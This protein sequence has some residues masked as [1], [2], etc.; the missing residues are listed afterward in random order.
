MKK[1]LILTIALLVVGVFSF[2]VN[3]TSNMGASTWKTGSNSIDSVNVV[4][5][6]IEAAGS[7]SQSGSSTYVISKDFLVTVQVQNTINSPVLINSLQFRL[8][9]PSGSQIQLVSFDNYS[10]DLYISND[11]NQFFSLVPSNSFSYGSGIVVPPN[12]SIWAVGTISAQMISSTAASNFGLTSVSV[13]T[14]TTARG[15]VYTYG[16][17]VDWSPLVTSLDTYFSQEHLDNNN[18]LTLLG[19]IK[20]DSAST[21]SLLSDLI[22]SVSYTGTSYSYTGTVPSGKTF[23]FTPFTGVTLTV[24]RIVGA[25]YLIN[26][27]VYYNSSSDSFSIDQTVRYPFLY[28]ITIA[29]GTGKVFRSTVYNVFN[30]FYPSNYT[31]RGNIVVPSFISDTY[32][33]HNYHFNSEFYLKH[34]NG[35]YGYISSDRY[36]FTYLYGY[37]E[38]PKNAPVPVWND[39]TSSVTFTPVDDYYP[40]T[41]YDILRDLYNGFANSGRSDQDQLSSDITSTSNSI[42]AQEEQYFASNAQAIQA[43]GLSNYRFDQNQS[44]GISAVSNDFTAV[45]NALGGF[46]SVFIFSLTLS[47]ALQIFRHHPIVFRAKQV[48][49]TPKV[50][51]GDP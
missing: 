47:L 51:K 50:G 40:L 28:L 29:N 14:F 39:V 31:Y 19:T 27:D 35:N 2:S 46:N 48:S 32:K 34:T 16:S 6:V 20:V 36:Q 23:T 12:S 49:T 37:I 41:E 10:T 15:D 30:N 5:D 1:K 11:G 26:E 38:V 33:G 4:V 45:F 18:I 8:Q 21:V 42:H 24:T 22:D 7:Y 17:P 44:G 25:S 13:P 9:F 3:A 43:T